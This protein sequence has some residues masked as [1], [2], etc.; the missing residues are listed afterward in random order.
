MA[1][2]EPYIHQEYPKWVKG[3]KDGQI[4]DLIVEDDSEEAK[5]TEDV[6]VLTKAQEE[7]AKVAAKANAARAKAAAKEA[8]K[9]A[10]EAAADVSEDDSEEAKA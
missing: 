4:V 7:A 8:V 5:A 6:E 2:P 1:Q 9:L 10:A 3:V